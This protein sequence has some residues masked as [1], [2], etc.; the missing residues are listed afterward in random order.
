MDLFKGLNAQVLGISI[1]HIACLQAWAESLGGINYPLLSDFWPHGASC[2]LYGVLRSQDGFSDRAIFVLD[3]KG[4]IRYIDI[5]PIDDRPDNDVLRQVLE[6]ILAEDLAGAKERSGAKVRVTSNSENP[7]GIYYEAPED[8]EIPKGEIVLYCAS[9]CKDCRKA[10]SWLNERGLQYIEVDI[11]SNVA[12]RRQVR[13]WS[14]GKLITPIVEFDG[15][16]I[17]D[18]DPARMEEALLKRLG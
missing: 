13:A 4:V 2:S 11:D 14:G 6:T 18:Y 10:R 15:M 16:V 5:H 8:A 7:S 3:T 17:M 12:A 1:D 9:W